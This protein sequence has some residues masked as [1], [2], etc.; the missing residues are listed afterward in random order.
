MYMYTVPNNIIAYMYT[1]FSWDTCTIRLGCCTDLCIVYLD[2]TYAVQVSMTQLL[3]ECVCNCECM[4]S[5]IIAFV[6]VFLDA[7]TNQICY[8]TRRS[9]WTLV[10]F[11]LNAWIDVCNI[12]LDR[13]LFGV[14]DNIIKYI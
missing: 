1:S 13:H 10:S 9:L 4:I 3:Y 11:G 6:Y 5:C 2:N 14:R 7:Q 8:I 12:Y